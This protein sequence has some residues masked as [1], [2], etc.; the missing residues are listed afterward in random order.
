MWSINSARKKLFCH[1]IVKNDLC[2][3]SCEFF[4]QNR[5]QVEAWNQRTNTTADFTYCGTTVRSS[6]RRCSIKKLFLKFHNIH[7]KHLRWSLFLI[8]PI[9]KNIFKRLLFNF[10]NG[11]LLHR[12][13]L[14]W[15]RFYAGFRLQGLGYAR[16]E[17]K[18]PNPKTM[19]PAF[20]RFNAACSCSFRVGTWDALPN[21]PYA[22]RRPRDSNAPSFINIP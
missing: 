12:P 3:V 9:L 6:H 17:S 18:A 4:Y 22:R 10:F 5:K 19:L 7:R 13:K 16:C 21:N 15:S 14:L 1:V 20:C 8:L 2:N 11:W